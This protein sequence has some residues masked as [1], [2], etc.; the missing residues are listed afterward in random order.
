MKSNILTPTIKQERS[1]SKEKRPSQQ[2]SIQD[3]RDLFTQQRQNKFIIQCAKGLKTT[4][5]QNAKDTTLSRAL[6]IAR[7][8]LPSYSTG[9]KQGYSDI[10]RQA[11]LTQG[12]V[13]APR[14]AAQAHHIVEASDD[15]ASYSRI[16][17]LKAGID[18]DSPI[19]GVF[20]PTSDFDG[21]PGTV[22]FG[23]HV[24]QYAQ[25]IDTILSKN[26]NDVGFS[27]INDIP[28]ETFPLF[29]DTVIQTL[30]GIRNMLLTNQISLNSHSDPPIDEEGETDYDPS[31]VVAQFPVF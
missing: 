24:P 16:V 11:L 9:K 1:L 21:Y 12:Q 31:S 18:L 26:L 20:L 28:A 4:D 3:N 19:N 14:I 22:H 10:L 23:S 17:L 27:N 13:P 5:Y 8:R 7:T 15:A 25:L 6:K 30:E 29:K 2:K